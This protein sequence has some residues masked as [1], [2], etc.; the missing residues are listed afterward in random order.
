MPFRI[1]S[2]Y[3]Y[4]AKIIFWNMILRL[5]IESYLDFAVDSGT[6]VQNVRFL[7]FHQF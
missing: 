1:E 7:F 2:I 4:L 3:N 6:N 5:I